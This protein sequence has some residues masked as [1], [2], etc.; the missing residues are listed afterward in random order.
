MANKGAVVDRHNH[1]PIRLHFADQARPARLQSEANCRYRSN[2]TP[3]HKPPAVRLNI[4]HGSG[5]AELELRDRLEQERRC[6]L[7]AIVDLA[8]AVL[9]VESEIPVCRHAAQI[10]A[11]LVP[12]TTERPVGSHP[13]P[14]SS[15]FRMS[16]CCRESG[17]AV[18]PGMCPLREELAS[19]CGEVG[20]SFPS[21]PMHSS[22]GLR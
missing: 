12:S 14:A 1:V 9:L 11:I 16:V 15:P 18:S 8:T 2:T 7:G 10:K 20:V 22:L 5:A 4:N 17:S 13:C 3:R 6:R 21:S 19:W